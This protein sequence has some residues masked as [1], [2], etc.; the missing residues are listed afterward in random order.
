[1]SRRSSLGVAVQASEAPPI[2]LRER[3]RRETASCIA[4][5][6]ED[7]FA[8]EGLH[9]A[10]VE[11]IARR[12]GVAV[13]TLYN[14][15][16]DRDALLAALLRTRREA[17]FAELDAAERAA[18]GRPIR[19]QLLAFVDAKVRFQA[20]HRTFFRILFEGEL[21]R[22]QAAYPT[23]TDEHE[24]SLRGFFERVETLIRRGVESGELRGG[25]ADLD[26][27]LLGG[28]IRSI[29][30]RDFREN[31]PCEPKDVEHLV[32]VFLA[33]AEA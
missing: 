13:G 19:D 25:N 6:A 23:A 7:V 16:K 30:V 26:M 32:D 27:W 1:V 21:S 12:A 33:G 29:S 4:S 24:R 2:L 20:A 10:H 8:A 15:Y 28:M 31:K 3:V 17:L 18:H 5:A 11:H 14:Y 22:M 9:A